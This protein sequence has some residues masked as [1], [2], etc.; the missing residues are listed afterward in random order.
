MELVCPAFDKNHD[1]WKKN[2]VSQCQKISLGVAFGTCIPISC[3]VENLL[4]VENCKFYV[5]NLRWDIIVQKVDRFDV[6]SVIL[7]KKKTKVTVIVGLLTKVKR[8]LKTLST[9]MLPN[10]I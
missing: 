5:A 7:R 9:P 10:G 2:F 1:F 8:R 6:S 4:V 3:N